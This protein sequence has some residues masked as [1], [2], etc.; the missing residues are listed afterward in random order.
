M[1]TGKAYSKHPMKT[2]QLRWPT[3]TNSCQLPYNQTKLC[4]MPSSLFL[5]SQ[6]N[7][8]NRNRTGFEQGYVHNT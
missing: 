8:A 6:I 4:S 7:L 2:L 1:D 3:L 5:E